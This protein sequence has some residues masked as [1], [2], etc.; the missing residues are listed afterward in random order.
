MA[1]E[2]LSAT[3]QRR[4]VRFTDQFLKNYQH[5]TPRDEIFDKNGNGLGVRITARA[6]TFFFIRRVKGKKTRFTLGQYPSMSLAEARRETH[7]LLDKINKAKIHGST[8][9]RASRPRPRRR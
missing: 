3:N 8:N 6:K 1:G 4:A 7:A 9:E 2:Q 5:A